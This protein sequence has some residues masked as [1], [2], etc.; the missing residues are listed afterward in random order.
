[1]FVRSEHLKRH[2]E[3]L[4]YATKGSF[5]SSSTVVVAAAV[6]TAIAFAFVVFVVIVMV[7][8]MCKSQFQ[9]IVGHNI[10]WKGTLQRTSCSCSSCCRAYY[11]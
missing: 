7:M 2:L 4:H 8:Q 11:L 6:V 3:E 9:T 10:Y 5:I 1:M